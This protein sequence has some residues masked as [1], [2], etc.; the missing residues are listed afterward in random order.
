MRAFLCSC[1]GTL[2]SLLSAC[3]TITFPEISA[4]FLYIV[5]SSYFHISTR[6]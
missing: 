1:C 5:D 2:L 3:K 4:E 6:R